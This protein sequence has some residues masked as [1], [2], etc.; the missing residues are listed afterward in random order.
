MKYA[1]F[2]SDVTMGAPSAVS[3]GGGYR[4]RLKLPSFSF[5]AAGII[6]VDPA[7][8]FRLRKALLRRKKN[9]R[10]STDRRASIGRTMAAAS[11]PLWSSGL[12]SWS[13]VGNEVD[14]EEDAV[15][16]YGGFEVLYVRVWNAFGNGVEMVDVCCELG[17]Q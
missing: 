8:L 5:I 9:V 10:P 14:E 4:C 17:V 12:F 3:S 16:Q 7:A 2:D 6:G 15:S 13:A 11:G 1:L